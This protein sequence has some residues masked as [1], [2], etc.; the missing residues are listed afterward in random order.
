MGDIKSW[1]IT[2]QAS[3]TKVSYSYIVKKLLSYLD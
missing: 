3:K 1:N 2:S